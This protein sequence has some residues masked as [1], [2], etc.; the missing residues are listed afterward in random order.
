M[1]AKNTIQVNSDPRHLLRYLK[2]QASGADDEALKR[3][4]K[5]ERVSLA[6]VKGSVIQ[7]DA[8]RKSNTASEMELAVRNLVISSVPKMQQTLHDLLDATE[9]VEEKVGKTGLTRVVKVPDKTTRLEAMRV[10]IALIAG[11][12]PKQAPVEVNVNQ[13][14]QTANINSG[15]ES[16]E[17][18]FRR[19]RKQAEAHNALPPETTGVP[20]YIDAGEDSDDDEDEDED[21]DDE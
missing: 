19:L 18:R 5:E 2:F 21:E 14:N 1:P 10:S 16:N 20:E 4:A 12:Q 8:Y 9:L 3:I 17:D 11:L 13:T 15:V 6:T 7:I